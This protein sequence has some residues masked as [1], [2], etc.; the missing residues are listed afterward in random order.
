MRTTQIATSAVVVAALLAVGGGASAQDVR[1]RMESP[2]GAGFLWT[3]IYT[4]F[5]EA[6]ADRTEG[7]VEIQVFVNSELSRDTIT[8]FENIQAGTVDGAVVNSQP[9]SVFDERLN[10][11]S[12]PFQVEDAEGYY[13][14]L[15]G[16][17]RELWDSSFEQLGVVGLTE[18]SSMGGF[19]QLTNS[20]RP[21]RTPA[22]LEGMTIRMPGS[23]L[24]RDIWETLGVNTSS[25]SFG[26]LLGALETR[27]VDGQENPVNIIE[28]GQL[29]NLQSY[30]T[31][32]NYSN[33]ALT[34]AFNA[35]SWAQLSPEQQDIFREEA[36]AAMVW[37]REEVLRVDDEL[38]ARY[39]A[40][41]RFDEITV[42]DAAELG[43]FRDAMVPVYEIW[44]ER[45]GSDVI[46]PFLPN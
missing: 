14:L 37:H 38:L 22:D 40:E 28:A 6:V 29:Y 39:E 34:F 32:W 18:A 10:V 20:V 13:A 35:D 16:P 2:V 27:V 30:V 43:A 15:D 12:L 1:L 33:S 7:A 36:K 4:R 46:G 31:I 45:L 5:A 44:T 17:G 42:L 11:F 41:N 21:V 19:R 26:E 8:Q 23:P 25:M 3:D 24:Y 9:L